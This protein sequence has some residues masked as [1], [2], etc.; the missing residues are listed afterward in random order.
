MEK[1][2]DLKMYDTWDR[3]WRDAGDSCGITWLGKWMFKAKKKSLLKRI[4]DLDITTAIEVGCGSGTTLEILQAAGLRCRGIDAS[5]HAV[6]NCVKKGL[7]ARLQ[8]MEE[9][10]E[11][12]DL[13]F[14]DG[15]L[16]HFL[17]FRPH[18][19]HFMAISRRYVLLIQPN[20][21]S[22]WGRTL[23]YLSGLLRQRQNVHEYNYRMDDFIQV[24]DENR[25]K[26]VASDP[27]FCDVFRLLLFEKTQ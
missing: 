26:L 13:V 8:K 1:D 10:Q 20:H 2:Q 16:E 17:D 18:A 27:V 24:F 23:A 14:S 7:N 3:H 4:S 6:E 9:V 5:P 22:F 21:D 12:F 19:R 25:F 11:Q 15:V